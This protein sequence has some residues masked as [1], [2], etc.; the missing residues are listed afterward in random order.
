MKILILTHEYP[1]VGGGG[2]NA[3]RFLASEF[4]EAGHAVHVLTAGYG[5]TPFREKLC[6]GR[7]VVTRVRSARSSRDHCSAPEMLAYLI[8]ASRE[9]KSIMKTETYDICLCFF[10]IPAGVLARRMKYRYGL[11]YVIRMGGGDIPGFQNRFK[12]LYRI[13]SPELRRIWRDA[14]ALVANSEGLRQ[15]AM[16]FCDRYPVQVIHNGVDTDMFTPPERYDRKEGPVKLLTVCRLIERKGI[17]DVIPVL[18]E[19]ERRTGNRI[20]LVIAGDGPYLSELIRIAKQNDADSCVEFKGYIE[21]SGLPDL[22]RSADIFVFPSYRE[23]MPNA[24]LEAMAS[25]LP[26]V[27]RSDCQGAAE[28]IS[29]NGVQAG[30][31]F[32]DALVELIKEGAGKWKEMGRAGRRTVMDRYTWK[33]ISLQY[34]DLLSRIIKDGGSQRR[35]GNHEI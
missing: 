35:K 24:V 10:G 27:M 23:G 9:A 3:C 7:L 13:I 25:G 22:Y 31:N 18:R 19:T 5:D 21:R 12:Q 29:D 14:E 33:H 4:A 30:E 34:T 20:R 6:D 1:P 2:A 11:R 28:L 32:S 16:E 8:K 26:V 17:Q 15:M